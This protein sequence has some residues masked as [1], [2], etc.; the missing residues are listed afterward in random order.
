WPKPCA[1]RRYG[2]APIRYGERA[3]A[4]RQQPA[5]QSERAANRLVDIAEASSCTNALPSIHLFRHEIRRRPSRPS[6]R[7]SCRDAESKQRSDRSASGRSTLTG[8]STELSALRDVRTG[9]CV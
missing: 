9:T 8:T 7:P 6:F 2:L 1:T 5:R 4:R 3:A